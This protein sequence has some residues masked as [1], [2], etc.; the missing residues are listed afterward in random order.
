MAE[1][2]TVSGPNRRNQRADIKAL[3]LNQI[4]NG[5]EII[6]TRARIGMR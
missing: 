5:L 2:P 1:S 3:G 6:I 4:G